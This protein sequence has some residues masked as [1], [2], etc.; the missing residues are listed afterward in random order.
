[1]DPLL[2]KH[3]Y[4][5]LQQKIKEMK[6]SG[7]NDFILTISEID[8]LLAES[9]KGMLPL[10]AFKYGPLY[11]GNDLKSPTHVWKPA[12]LTNECYITEVNNL[13][14]VRRCGTIHFTF[15]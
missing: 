14:N 7:V 6:L 10:S 11:W 9:N 4:Y 12:W 13:N 15:R 8:Q 2:P 5:P 3:K 1:M